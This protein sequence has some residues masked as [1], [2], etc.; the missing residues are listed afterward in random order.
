MGL[1]VL[2][3]LQLLF[4]GFGAVNGFAFQ[5]LR[6]WPRI[7]GHL[8]AA[9]GSLTGIFYSLLLLISKQ[10]FALELAPAFPLGTLR[11]ECDLISGFFVFVIS[12]ISFFCSVYAVSYTKEHESKKSI[13]FL[14]CF[15]NLF[16]LSMILVVQV[17]NAFYFLI[18][19]SKATRL[20]CPNIF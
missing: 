7:A 1:T 5:R 10:S 12:L 11:F 16:I 4:Y 9:A 2:F 19:Y 13:P 14:V 6:N 20:F 8:L 18:F 15:Y 3:L 17:Q